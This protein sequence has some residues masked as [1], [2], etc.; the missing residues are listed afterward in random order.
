MVHFAE[1][2]D[3]LLEGKISPSIVGL[4]QAAGVLAYIVL[5]A[6][7]F[8]FLGRLVEHDP[9]QIVAMTVMLTL[10]VFSAAI[11]GTLVLGLPVYFTFAKNNVKRGLS[12]LAYTLLYLFA[13]V[14][15]AATV[16][17]IVSPK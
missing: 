2:M 16:L 1:Q 4:Y 13:V 12:I 3:K 17:A 5:I 6:S 10:L 14:I 15:T 11:T 7:F 8:T 9:P